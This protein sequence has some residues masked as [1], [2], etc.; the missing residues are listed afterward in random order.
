MK[1]ALLLACAALLV[2]LPAQASANVTAL[3]PSAP[4]SP[5]T[6]A[7]AI[8]NEP[9]LI[10]SASLPERAY[11]GVGAPSPLGLGDKSNATLPTVLA[12][13]PTFG[14]TYAILSSG[15]INSVASVLNQVTT[16]LN[17]TYIFSEQLED[18]NKERG[19]AAEDYTVWK[20]DVDVPPGASCLALDYRFLSEEFPDYVGEEYND[21]FIAE[22]DESN[23]SVGED[24]EIS[25]PNDFAVSAAG[26]PIS[27]NGVGDTAMFP[28][29]AEGTYFN[30]ATAL[31]TTKRAITPGAHAIYLSIFDASDESLDSAIFVDNLRFTSESSASCKPPEGKQLELPPPLP[32]PQPQPTPT[33][34]SNTFDIGPSVKFSAKT[35]SATLTLNVP[36]PGT[37][38]AASPMVAAASAGLVERSASAAAKPKGGKGK[39]KGKS[40]KKKKVKKPLLIGSTVRA[41]GPGPVS[42]TVR[43]SKTGKALLAKRGKLTI[44]VTLTFSPDGGTPASQVK[45]VTF[46]KAKP[47]CGKGKGKAKSC[48]KGKAKGSPKKK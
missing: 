48:G 11:G 2:A 18:T 43:L 4:G 37:V 39:K 26:Q 35:T 25:R 29:E 6:A 20:I 28:T 14:N 24:G 3:D 42:V 9:A 31:I 38:T 44:P 23:W 15:E 27:V 34:P 46:K 19:A 7:Q 40:K 10:D 47:K 32:A 8:V 17:R 36:G 1:K 5:I 33:A 13:F 12:G 41:N 16:P 22:I 30:A 21:A 45:S